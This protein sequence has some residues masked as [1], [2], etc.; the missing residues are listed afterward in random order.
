M[1]PQSYP[2]VSSETPSLCPIPWDLNQMKPTL[3]LIRSFCLLSLMLIVLTG[4]KTSGWTAWLDSDSMTPSLSFD[5]VPKQ[6][7]PPLED[8]SEETGRLEN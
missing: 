6:S 2:V 7:E 8:V 1:N 4:C 3:Q 5:V